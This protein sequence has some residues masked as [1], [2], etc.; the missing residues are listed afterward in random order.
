[1]VFVSKKDEKLRFRGDYRRLSPLTVRDANTL[2]G[3]DEGTYYLGDAKIFSTVNC[4]SVY[5]QIEIPGADRDKAIVSSN[6]RLLGLFR[7]PSY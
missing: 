5:Q 4:S 2:F 6:H 7:C 1:M 3:R